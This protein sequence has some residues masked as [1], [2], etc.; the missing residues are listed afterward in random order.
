[1]RSPTRTLETSLCAPPASTT[2]PVAK[3]GSL[4]RSWSTWPSPPRGN[5]GGRGVRGVVRNSPP[6][7]RLQGEG[8][9]GLTRNQ[10]S[11]VNAVLRP[12]ASEG[13]SG[14]GRRGGAGVGAPTVPVARLCGHPRC[15]GLCRPRRAG[16]VRSPRGVGRMHGEAPSFFDLALAAFPWRSS[17]VRRR[18]A[19]R[20]S[21]GGRASG[22][23]RSRALVLEVFVQ[24]CPGSVT[25]CCVGNAHMK[26]DRRSRLKTLYS[27]S[28]RG[29]PLSSPARGVC[30]APAINPPSALL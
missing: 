1:M 4:W 21:L 2:G 23:S 3:D 9:H 26:S 13:A 11:G 12:R 17:P 18:R 28:L 20:S 15:G 22:W 25:E 14:A 30:V 27:S 8:V 29:P 19:L 6:S 16:L 24:E 5:P 7:M 10:L